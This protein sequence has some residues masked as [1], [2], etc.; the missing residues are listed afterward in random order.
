MSSPSPRPVE[1]EK[2]ESYESESEDEEVGWRPNFDDNEQQDNFTRNDDEAYC[3]SDDSDKEFKSDDSH[4]EGSGY[5]GIDDVVNNSNSYIEE[6]DDT[7]TS[8]GSRDE[9]GEDDQVDDAL[10][11]DTDNNSQ[12][13]DEYDDGNGS[14]S[15]SRFSSPRGERSLHDK[16]DS[17]FYSDDRSFHSGEESESYYS[18]EGSRSRTQSE[19]ELNLSDE[20][21]FYSDGKSDT[22]TSEKKGSHSDCSQEDSYNSS[23][24]QSLPGGHDREK[25]SQQAEHNLGNNEQASINSENTNENDSGIENENESYQSEINDSDKGDDYFPQI[26]SNEL[27]T[28]LLT[29]NNDNSIN[30]SSNDIVNT[31]M[32]KL[33]HED[34]QS[35][36]VSDD[37]RSINSQN[38]KAHLSDSKRSYESNS[39]NFQ[40]DSQMSSE[41]YQSESLGKG[42]NNISTFAEDF[43]DNKDN[44][45]SKSP[46][47]NDEVNQQSFP[48]TTNFEQGNFQ[49]EIVVSDSVESSTKKMAF[50]DNFDED[51]YFAKNGTSHGSSIKEKS[52]NKSTDDFG[53]ARYFDDAFGSTDLLFSKTDETLQNTTEEYSSKKVSDDNIENV[54][55][56]H[57]KIGGDDFGIDIFAG[58]GFPRESVKEVAEADNK[59]FNESY[60][61]KDY[62]SA[63]EDTKISTVVE[64]Q[65]GSQHSSS[66]GDEVDTADYSE[67]Y[68]SEGYTSAEEN[69]KISTVV[70]SQGGLQHS[71]NVGDEA[72]SEDYSESYSSEGYTSAEEDI[73]I[74]TVVESQEGSQHSSSV[75][76]EENEARASQN[77]SSEHEEI[78]VAEDHDDKLSCEE[79]T[80]DE[81]DQTSKPLVSTTQNDKTE[82]SFSSCDSEEENNTN[83]RASEPRSGTVSFTVK[84]STMGG[85]IL[86]ILCTMFPTT[87][88]E[89]HDQ[90]QA[91]KICESN[92]ILPFILMGEHEPSQRDELL[93]ISEED[94][95]PQFFLYWNQNVEFLGDFLDIYEMDENDDFNQGMLEC[96]SSK[97][98]SNISH[99]EDF[100]NDQSVSVDSKEEKESI[101]SSFERDSI[102]FV[103]NVEGDGSLDNS[104]VNDLA[105]TTTN[106][107]TTITVTITITVTRLQNVLAIEPIQI[108][109]HI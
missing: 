40:E 35:K 50:S 102:S 105:L 37:E 1:F 33:Q 73:K 107:I 63:E 54:S 89:T 59:Y 95:F 99:A 38:N 91:A 9:I 90:N 44:D 86:I 68:S 103:D 109:G 16:D 69:M 6:E 101:E 64:S 62:S 77:D 76:D 53:S 75:R 5:T 47:Q 25:S 97:M 56:V 85:K 30:S 23:E 74:S 57:E 108:M 100:S 43:S 87:E 61:S 4:M 92:K 71:S 17:S 106:I 42:V 34:A 12:K 66:V 55:R 67:S 36:H 80:K 72:D 21:S 104:C 78:T 3:S 7:H 20:K 58:D 8:T 27:L 26:I 29:D 41:S 13:E 51:D 22:S 49:K 83:P 70:E 79:I 31:G 96:S 94:V 39:D 28:E 81:N 98:I 82:K 52:S 19:S 48:L 65:E 14:Y 10:S 11:R 46:K 88:T 93:A 84:E 24:T 18:E 60:S 32:H 15:N 45:A 2:E